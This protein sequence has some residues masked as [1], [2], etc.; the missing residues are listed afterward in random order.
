MRNVA[1]PIPT[2]KTIET[3]LKSALPT[4]DPM[5]TAMTRPTRVPTIQ[6]SW[7][8]EMLRLISILYGALK[9]AIL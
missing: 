8:V 4:A 3:K 7:V 1:M 6:V 5:N 9:L 2:P